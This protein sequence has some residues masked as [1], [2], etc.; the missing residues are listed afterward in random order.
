MG[1]VYNNQIPTDWLEGM[2]GF[3]LLDAEQT[4]QTIRL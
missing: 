2:E 1:Q 4:A 3:I